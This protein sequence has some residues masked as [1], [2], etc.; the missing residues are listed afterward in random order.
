MDSVTLSTAL[1]TITRER[2]KYKAQI[3]GMSQEAATADALGF[4]ESVISAVDS[5]FLEFVEWVPVN[6]RNPRPVQRAGQHE[7]GRLL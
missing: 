5:G 2:I 1:H 4:A 7:Q 3:E 6:P